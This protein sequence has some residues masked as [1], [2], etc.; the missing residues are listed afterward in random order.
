MLPDGDRRVSVRNNYEQPI[1]FTFGD[2]PFE[3]PAK[4]DRFPI[5]TFDEGTYHFVALI[6]GVAFAEGDMFVVGGRDTVLVF[7]P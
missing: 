5:G 4:A 1:Q 2:K 7:Y 3:V 6:P